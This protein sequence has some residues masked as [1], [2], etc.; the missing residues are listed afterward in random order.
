MSREY[1][2][3]ILTNAT[4]TVLYTGVTNNSDVRLWQHR[5]SDRH[6][7]TSRYNATIPVYCESFFDVREAIAAEKRIKGWTRAKKVA[8][9]ESVN[10]E[11]RDIS[12]DLIRA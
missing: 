5:Q 9:I 6:S 4:Y 7:F 2:V 3:Y 8:L 1:F 12:G 11:W 10:P